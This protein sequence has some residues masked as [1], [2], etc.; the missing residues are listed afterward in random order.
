MAVL[1]TKWVVDLLGSRGGQQLVHRVH[2]SEAVQLL[3]LDFREGHGEQVLGADQLCN[4]SL[5]FHCVRT[6]GASS[7]VSASASS[8]SNA[9][10]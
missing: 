8:S 3:F 4:E 2:N 6:G 7:S 10:A 5:L 9:S 1:E